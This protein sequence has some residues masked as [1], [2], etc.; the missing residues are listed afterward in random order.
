MSSI[1][2]RN[3]FRSKRSSKCFVKGSMR[4]KASD[5]T[6]SDRTSSDR[7]SSADLDELARL[8]DGR[9]TPAILSE[10]ANVLERV[11]VDDQDIRAAARLDFAEMRL[12]HDLGIY[13]GCGP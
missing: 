9:Q 7:T 10:H 13:G 1:E 8:H 6:S 5:R 4:S 3:R 11:S 2:S 12:H